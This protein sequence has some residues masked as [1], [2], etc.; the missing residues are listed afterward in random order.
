M[1]L[2]QIVEGL[3]VSFGLQIGSCAQQVGRGAI[4]VLKD[5]RGDRTGRLGQSTQIGENS[6]ADAEEL[7]GLLEGQSAVDC[8]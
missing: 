8:L 5:G 4:A 1:K 6:P 3:F 2:G 7:R